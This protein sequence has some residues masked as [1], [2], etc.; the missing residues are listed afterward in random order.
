MCKMLLVL[1]KAKIQERRQ[2]IV[3][4]R[5]S[6]CIHR[7]LDIGNMILSQG[8]ATLLGHGQELRGEPNKSKVSMEG[9]GQDMNVFRH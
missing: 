8:H 3:L 4:I 9:Y 7:K 5:L 1:K 2:N 6:P